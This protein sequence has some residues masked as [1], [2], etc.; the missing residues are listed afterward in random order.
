MLKQVIQ[1]LDEV[2]QKISTFQPTEVNETWNLLTIACEENNTKALKT[3]RKVS[4][5]SVQ[6]TVEDDAQIDGV[7]KSL[8]DMGLKAHKMDMKAVLL[9]R[10]AERQ[11]D[12]KKATANVA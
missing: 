7:V 6:F 2:D 10:R 11:A 4:K 9:Q 1:V 8:I 5:G 3:D 12:K